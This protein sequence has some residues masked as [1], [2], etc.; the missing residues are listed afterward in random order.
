MPSSDK[1]ELLD[2]TKDFLLEIGGWRTFKEGKLLWESRKVSDVKIEDS[3]LSGLIQSGTTHIKS[4]LKLGRR[5]SEIENL[6]SCRQAREYGTICPHVIAI[7]LAWMDMKEQSCLSEARSTTDECNSGSDN[8][9]DINFFPVIPFAEA[10]ALAPHLEIHIFLPKDLSQAWHK[11]QIQAVFEASINSSPP[12]PLATIPWKNAERYAMTDSDIDLVKT[13]LKINSGELPSVFKIQKKQFDFFFDSLIQHPNVFYNR[14]CRYEITP[15]IT[16]QTLA[17]EMT[18][19]GELKL[20]LDTPGSTGPHLLPSPCGMW[21]L[22]NK[23]LSRISRLPEHFQI[24]LETDMLLTREQVAHFLKKDLPVLEQ[25]LHVALSEFCQKLELVSSHPDIHVHLDGILAGISCQLE[26]LY[27]DGVYILTGRS[28]DHH[29]HQEVWV[30][31]PL[32]PQK[33]Y[34]RN[35]EFENRV[36]REVLACSFQPGNKQ[37]NLYTLT[38]E[39][40]VGHFLANILKRWKSKWKVSCSERFE[41][42]VA[43]CDFVEPEIRIDSPSNNWLEIDIRYNQSEGIPSLSHSEIQTLINKGISHQRSPGDRITLISSDAIRELGEVLSDCHIRQNNGIIHLESKFAGFLSAAIQS[44][45]WNINPNGTWQ[46]PK[47]V[48]SFTSIELLQHQ[49]K[50]LRPYQRKGIE[51]LAFLSANSFGGIL[52]DEMGLGKTLQ[53][54]YFLLWF[55][56]QKTLKISHTPAQKNLP[57]Q[58]FLVI[59]PTSL[60][61]NWQ[62]EIQRFTPEFKSLVI[63]GSK[64]KPLFREIPDHDIII[65]SY[66]LLR[67]D[68][69]HYLPINF[70]AIILDEAQHI[71]NKSSQNAQSAKQLRSDFRLVLSGT[72]IENSLLDLWSIFDFL[73]PGYLGSANEFKNRYELPIVKDS[74]VNAQ[75]RLRQKVQP[76]ILRRTKTEVAKDLP[77]KLEHQSLCELTDEQVKVYREILD[78]GRKEVFSGKLSSDKQ[79]MAILTILTRLR[80]ACCDLR[81]LKNIDPT[82]WQEPSC[83]MNSFLELLEQVIDGGHRVLVFS[84]FV[85]MLTIIRAQLDQNSTPYSYLDGAT[86]NRIQQVEQFQNNKTIPVF[87]ISLKAGGTGLNL[88]GADT[89]IHFDPW[90]NPAVEDQATARAHRIGQTRIVNSYKL[91]ARGTVEEKILQLQER[92]K[93]LSANTL[94]SE[95]TFVRKL[96]SEDLEFLFND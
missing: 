57:P 34:I 85:S 41:N 96:N 94:V 79:R 66:S 74:D 17:V 13:L 11:G 4:R 60:V 62:N 19:T 92:K 67:R 18:E 3:I 24:L 1:K 23:K 44:N 76:F 72:P 42:L 46:N 31:D 59:C 95:E 45:Q 47:E 73:M 52:A 55:K 22:D 86:T 30:P 82:K 35:Y 43:R 16:Q 71:K 5:L 48:R 8:S 32:D 25:H 89:V 20:H 14:E 15:Q 56:N 29:D 70:S 87:L 7:G 77:E 63:H 21:K 10:T 26:A 28:L 2:V 12:R 68:L 64:R 93:D 65:T 27:P 50:I 53:T 61:F 78:L 40:K 39:S 54:L 9:E 83:K 69:D 84:Q 88:T 58:P 38:P 49:D 6:C 51:W 36:I 33:Y 81:L 91:I 37:P 90:W 75:N 80:Q